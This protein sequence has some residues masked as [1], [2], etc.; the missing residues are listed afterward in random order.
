[1][2]SSRK[3]DVAIKVDVDRMVSLS[4]AR[5]RL[6]KI[7]EKTAGD[8]FWVVTRGACGRDRGRGVP[9]STGPSCVL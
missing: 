7:V 2:H 3:V 5:S 4:E 6:S 1:M 9:G 8:Q